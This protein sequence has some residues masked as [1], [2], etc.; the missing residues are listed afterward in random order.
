MTLNIWNL[1][2]PWRQRR[3]E[4][5]AWLVRLEPDVVC[6]QEVVQAPDGRNQA[7]W[8]AAAPGVDALGYHVA[9]GPGILDL[10]HQPDEYCD[11]ADLINATKVIA[12][13]VLELTGTV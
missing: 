9:Y 2:G 11:V 7:R 8:L 6:L 4:I 1:A 13:A 3:E 5:A 10:A 12:L